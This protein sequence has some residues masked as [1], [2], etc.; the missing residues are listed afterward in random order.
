MPTLSTILQEFITLWVVIDPI[1]TLPVFL[2]VTAG[3]GGLARKRVAVRAVLTAF[4]VLMFFLVAGQVVL[5]A[6]GLGLPSFQIA[7]GI[8]L[9][10]F[11]LTM[12][13]GDG[14]PAREM[15]EEGAIG[16]ASVYP[17][18][19][20]SIASPGAMLSVV[21]LT[22]N[23]RFSMAHQAMTSAVMAVVLGITLVILLLAGPILRLIGA[24]G[25]AI[26][27][28][29]M[30]IILAAVAVDAVLRGLVAFFT[31]LG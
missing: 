21:L 8:V 23:D 11:A 1:G 22:D 3:M 4:V 17:L 28:R 19:I 20:P 13:F 10:L 9:F 18:A 5:E 7:G 2:A 30:G 31:T 15:E 29:I 25:A 26:V 16:A 12:I 24:S 14:K 27:S 6:L